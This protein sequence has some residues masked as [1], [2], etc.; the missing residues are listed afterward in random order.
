M[1]H[2]L[3]EATEMDTEIRRMLK[4]QRPYMRGEDVREV[5]R[6]LGITAD[7]IY[8]PNT[9]AAVVAFQQNNGLAV[10]GIVGPS[11]WAALQRHDN[12]A[13]LSTSSMIPMLETAIT[14]WKQRS[15]LEKWMYG[16]GG[17]ALLVAVGMIVKNQSR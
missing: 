9:R 15:R 10:D 6:K 16:T 14:F 5:Q 2:L 7:G 8:G 12:P 4:L 3:G 13:V 1:S 17:V 11:T